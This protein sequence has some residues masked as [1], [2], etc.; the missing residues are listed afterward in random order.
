MFLL[1][2]DFNVE[3]V[4]VF[5]FILAYSK[6]YFFI[7]SLSFGHFAHFLKYPNHKTSINL[8]IPVTVC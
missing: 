2:R 5:F 6:H 8:H 4:R 3:S 1:D 7:F